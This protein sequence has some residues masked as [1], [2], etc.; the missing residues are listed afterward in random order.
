MQVLASRSGLIEYL[1]SDAAVYFPPL[2]WQLSADG[3]T[4][5]DGQ[6]WGDATGWLSMPLGERHDVSKLCPSLPLALEPSQDPET[7]DTFVHLFSDELTPVV[8]C[9]GLLL[10]PRN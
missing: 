1:L 10:E 4:Y 2:A 5:L 7:W 9:T 8:E 6:G 3:S